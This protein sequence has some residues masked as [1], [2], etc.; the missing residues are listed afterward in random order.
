[1]QVLCDGFLLISVLSQPLLCWQSSWGSSKEWC[2]NGSAA[3]PAVLVP[4]VGK[5]T[6]SSAQHGG[7]S[8]HFPLTART[9]TSGKHK[10]NQ[11]HQNDSSIHQELCWF[12]SAGLPG[13]GFWMAPGAMCVALVTFSIWRKAPQPCF[14][15]GWEFSSKFLSW[16]VRMI[17]VEGPETL[18][19]VHWLQLEL[20]A[21]RIIFRSSNIGVTCPVG[22]DCANTE[23]Q[24]GSGWNPRWPH[25]RS[26]RS[27]WFRLLA[28]LVP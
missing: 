20:P 28:T 8:A 23:S 19:E 3:L 7:N 18:S 13:K 17:Q 25:S 22:I 9:P 2:W 12:N 21:K 4:S 10:E 16:A 5:V 27:L 14:P 6:G 15:E 11:C 26:S 24:G 1:M